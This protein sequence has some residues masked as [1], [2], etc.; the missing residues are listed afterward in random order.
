MSKGTYIGNNYNKQ[1][2]NCY[3]C[4]KI[5][6]PTEMRVIS[7]SNRKIGKGRAIH[8]HLACYTDGRGKPIFAPVKTCVQCGN[9]F[10]KKSKCE[11]LCDACVGDTDEGTD[12]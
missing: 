12:R 5:I 7:N 10:I 3:R 4:H 11:L 2:T 8:R 6:A 1:K 9:Q